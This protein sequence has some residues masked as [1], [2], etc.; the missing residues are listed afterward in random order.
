MTSLTL[1]LQKAGKL[2]SAEDKADILRAARGHRSDGLDALAAGRLALVDQHAKVAELL[3]AEVAR[4]PGAAKLAPA[5]KPEASLFKRLFDTDNF[6]KWFGKSKVV[7]AEGKPLT[8]YHGTSGSEDGNAYTSFDTYASNYGLM[9]MGGYFTDNP[10][11]ASSYTSKGKGTS[12]SVYPVHL[13]IERPIDMD[14]KANPAEWTKQFDGIAEHHEGGTTNE[15]WYR[16][17]ES[18]LSDHDL[19]KWEGAEIMQ[20]GLRS[21]GYDGITHIGGGRVVADGVRH[22]VYIA[23]EPEQIKSATGNNGEYSRTDPRMNYSAREDQTDT[24]SFER[25]SHGAPVI[26]LAAAKNHVFK[27]GESVTVQA[28]HGSDAE[29]TEFSAEKSGSGSSGKIGR[30][31][32]G[33]G[34]FYLTTSRP[35]AE[36]HG[37]A[38]TFYV[39]I[40][41]PL[42]HDATATIDAWRKD[43]AEGASY[44]DAQSFVDGYYDKDAYAALNA[45]D[46]FA[47]LVRQAKKDGNDGIIIDF[48]KLKQDKAFELGKVIIALD[49]KQI[50]SDNGTDPRINYSVREDQDTGLPMNRDGTVSVY[51]HTSAGKASEIARTGRLKSAG[52]PD[53]YVTTHKQTDTG[54]GDTAVPLRV[55]PAKL[56]LDD[57]FPDGRKDFRLS[58]G[59]PGGSIPVQVGHGDAA[60]LEDV[61]AQWDAAGIKN[62]VHESKGTISLSQIVVPASERMSGKGTAAMQT[63]IDYADRTGQRITLTPDSA[64]GGSKA[65]LTAFYKGLGFVENK[66]RNKDFSTSERMIREPAKE[67][68]A[69]DP[70]INYSIAST[71]GN[72]AGPGLK[73]LEAAK[74][75]LSDLIDHGMTDSGA[76]GMAA[77]MSAGNQKTRSM[78]QAYV[79]AE[80]LAT[81]Q[82]GQMETTLTKNFTEAQR[83]KMWEAADEQNV[84]LQQPPGTPNTAPGTVRM[85]H[86]GQGVSANGKLWTTSDKSVAEGHAAQPGS[87]GLHYVDVP[88]SHPLVKPSRPG[89][90]VAS[91]HHIDVELPAALAATKERYAEP[92]TPMTGKGLDRLSPE[93]RSAVEMLHNYGEELLQRAKDVG[94]FKGEGLPYWTPRM[95]AM[96]D[97]NGDYTRLPSGDGKTA[98]SAGDGRN[99]TTS[100]A[101]LKGRKY[102]TADETEAAMKGKL[103]ANAELVRDIRTMPLAMQKLERAIAG[104]ELIN[105]IKALGRVTGQATVSPTAAPEFFTID[106]PAFTTFSPRMGED[107]AGNFTALKDANGNVIMDKK[108]IYISKEFEGPLKAI[109]SQQ[110]GA[111]YRAYMLLKS[112]AMSAIMISPLTHNMVIAGRAFAYAGLKLPVLYF[113]GHSAR[114][115]PDLMTNAISHGMVPISGSN[116]SMVDVGDIARGFGKDGGWGDPNESWIG[117]GAKAIGNKMAPGMGTKAKAGID[118]AGDFW[119][120]TLLWNRI[121]DLQAGIF[122]HAHEAALKKGMDENAASTYA[123]H[124]ANRYAGA[125]GKENM[126][127]I[128]RKMANVVLFS[129]SFNMGN[130]GAVKDVFYGMPAGLRAQLMEHSSS[131]SAAMGLSMAKRK[132]FTGLVMDFASSVL[133]TSL[134]Q[135]W[136]RR[137]KDDP[138]AKQIIDAMGGYSERAADMWDN[139]KAHPTE[140][141]SYDPYRLSSTWHNEPGKQDRI[142]MGAQESGRHE[143]MRLPTGKVIED[144]IGWLLHPSDTFVKKLSPMVKAASDIAT[145]DKGYDIP[146]WDPSGSTTQKAMDIAMHLFE[147]QLPF[148]SIRTGYDLANGVAT[149]L[150]KKKLAGNM[151]GLSVSP[152]HPLGP[153][154]ALAAKVEER[155]TESKA[156]AMEEVK[157]ALKYGNV[158]DA[159]DALIHTGLTPR[160]AQLAINRIENPKGRLSKQAIKKFNQHATPEEF[161][162]RDKLN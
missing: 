30:A 17:A 83:K 90:T 69:D 98:S 50:R 6:K 1:C 47:D 64:F 80:R 132:A 88:E 148:D 65:R 71:I 16:A 111:I 122:Q 39:A 26:D 147:A 63:L 60:S 11:V 87:G 158:D 54:Y 113:T 13:S 125:V 22:R 7:D 154:G 32:L 31:S 74:T 62:A 37:E 84:L 42:V 66:G 101:S 36:L 85:Y 146:V 89:A 24:P 153:E 8:M 29:F 5:D 103:G 95:A 93:E 27:N 67:S 28:Y 23:F 34:V 139:I 126:S 44:R 46:L 157:R 10:T 70:R 116:H 128:A 3:K 49:P 107:A 4:Q 161:E 56:Q 127:A 9:G 137:N 40:Q 81:Y 15:S 129:R 86:G 155:V 120:G 35:H 106:H 73:L 150:D 134:V 76:Y 14:A 21:M 78:A 75:R 33:G 38:K 20:D 130:I 124:V 19:P 140:R 117:L 12:P 152:G 25:W 123:A 91:G 160:E 142:D 133:L 135:D 57:E 59:R 99:F 48:G 149:P 96:L 118:K 45:D 97:A 43:T 144:T 114:L 53:V 136:Y 151:T 104:R 82:W 79:N 68:A 55:D 2:L 61:R 138:A 18:M 52:E 108:P 131:E 109:L 159:R 51:H 41:N 156:Y 115:D 145:N 110:D 94:M 102:L 141:G 92:P 100:A 162:E 72:Y 143:Y 77:P 112:K 58:V 119:H 105:Q 121:G